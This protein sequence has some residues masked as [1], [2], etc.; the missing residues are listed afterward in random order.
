[1]TAER[2]FIVQQGFEAPD[3]VSCPLLTSALLFQPRLVGLWALVA[4]LLQS[5][6]LFAALAAVLWW[7]ALLPRW[8]PFDALHNRLIAGR[9]R[10]PP[11]P[12]PRRFAQGM[13]GSFAAA[14]AVCLLAGAPRTALIIEVVFFSAVAAIAFG[15]FC[16]GSFL[17]HLAHGR[18]SFARRTLPWG[19]GV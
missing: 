2:N 18:V 15:R 8:N 7:S 9:P 6:P 5:G 3:A 4:A 11:A 1:L 10:L 16:L 14:I 19:R 12:G 17:F 13:A